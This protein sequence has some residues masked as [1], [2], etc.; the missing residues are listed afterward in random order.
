[1]TT[2]V[3]TKEVIMETLGTVL[4]PEIEL[5]VTDLGLVYG[6][7]IT[8]EGQMVTIRMTL[9]TPY[10]PYGPTLIAD[11]KRAV[12]HLPGVNQVEVVVVWDPPWDPK[13]MVSEEIK[14][15]LGIW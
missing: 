3:V 7:D 8:N 6:I 10:C 4:D 15:K 13:T 12:G 14:D 9:T 5:S 2:S 11:V 1:M